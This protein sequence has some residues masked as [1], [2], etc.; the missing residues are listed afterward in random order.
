VLRQSRD[1]PTGPD[2]RFQT[3]RPLHPRPVSRQW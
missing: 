1:H 2:R 3:P